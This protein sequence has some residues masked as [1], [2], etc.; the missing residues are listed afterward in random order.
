LAICS[1]V[2]SL[3]SQSRGESL[4]STYFSSFSPQISLAL[5]EAENE[6]GA[7]NAT[8]TWTSLFR[9]RLGGTEVPALD[10]LSLVEET[11]TS[12]SA[13]RKQ[14]ALK[15]LATLMSPH[16]V[17]FPSS[18]TA[19]AQPVPKE[20]HPSTWGEIWTVYRFGLK[21]LDRAMEDSEQSVAREARD[22]LLSSARTVIRVGLPEEIIT[23]LERLGPRDEDERR[24]ARETLRII[25]EYENERLNE[26]Q[27]K[28]LMTIEEKLT[29]TDFHDRLRRWT[30]QW[31][32]GDWD[33]QKRDGGPPA[34]NRAAALAEEALNRP[35]E[36][37]AELN[38][39]ASDEAQNVAHFAKRLGELDRDRDWLSE[40]ITKTRDGGRP[41]LLAS[42]LWGRSVTGD[43]ELVENL[44]DEWTE[45]DKNLASVVLTTTLYL[46]P[47]K[48]ALQR[49]LELVEKGWLQR[50][51][52]SIIAWSVWTEKLPI[53]AFQQLIICLMFD[54]SS[55]V[56][57]AALHSLDRRLKLFPYERTILAPLAWQ[58]LDRS[59]AA[60]GTMPQYYWGEVSK[61][62]VESDPV[63]IAEAVLKICEDPEILLDKE[64]PPMQTLAKASILRPIE[65]W[66][67]IAEALL[68]KDKRVYGL[69]LGL[70]GWYVELFSVDQLLEWADEHTPEGARLIAALTKPSGTPLAPL[71]RQLLIRFGE[72]E[73]VRN[74]LDANFQ[75]GSFTGSMTNWL[76]GELET[77]RVWTNDPHPSVREWAY[78]IV[79]SLKKQ[80]Q[81]WEKRE[82]EE[83][84]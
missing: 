19:G 76:R 10:R 36:L 28:R 56:E 6:S 66:D 31:S 55:E 54:H 12:G 17:R 48:K 9:L 14:L 73:F 60:K 63:R 44:L 74:A 30:G 38:W 8:G 5:A 25:L 1:V 43:K 78:E 37:R 22:V 47:S 21:L 41:I 33:I 84:G 11:L 79:D 58:L 16:E 18:E 81:E 80:I 29:G 15:A 27:H 4:A 68:R 42:Y 39:L 34:Q 3:C 40:L 67:I 57:Q 45:G 46:E 83:L 51:E 49:L 61:H 69:L 32:F 64:D 50:K 77:A 53:D 59:S 2:I 71:P 75:S 24:K 82:Q 62:Y 35:E 72:D 23:R 7:D 52:L 70:T 20:W 65:V 26:D 13:I